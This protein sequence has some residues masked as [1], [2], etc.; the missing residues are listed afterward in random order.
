MRVQGK[1]KEKE[2]RGVVVEIPRV[3]EKCHSCAFKF[4]CGFEGDAAQVWVPGDAPVG[5]EVEVE[6][7]EAKAILLAFLTFMVPVFIY[8]AAFVLL[9]LRFSVGVSAGL[10]LVP[11]LLWFPLL[12]LFSGF[13]KPRLV[14]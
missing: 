8:I 14:R 1:V 6:L 13:F 7:S 10:A 3:P 4:M 11:M 5:S 12:N 9:R 2:G